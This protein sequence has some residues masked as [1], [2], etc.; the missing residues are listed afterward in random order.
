MNV[1]NA[2]SITN[3]T[4]TEQT[5]P[6]AVVYQG[7]GGFNQK[8][9]K[10]IAPLSPEQLAL[11][12]APHH[13]SLGMA[14]QHIVMDRAWWF[15]TWMGEGGPDMAQFTNW[16]GE[17]QPVRSPAELV[18]GL[19]ATWRMIEGALARRTI[20]DLGQ[21]FQPPAS[22]SEREREI[23]GPITLQELIWHVHSHE[24]HHGGELAT[25][26]GEHGLPTLSGWGS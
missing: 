24:Y 9:I 7:W 16:D 21:V 26:M 17:D 2:T 1:A 20:A 3:A 13:W 18:S 12:V 11:P 8:L 15:H 5:V 10:V 6:L 4:Q 23:F 19:E 22:L 25:G 14:I